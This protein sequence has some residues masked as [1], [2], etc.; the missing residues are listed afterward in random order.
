MTD[1]SGWY[2]GDPYVF[3]YT[4]STSPRSIDYQMA[5][6]MSATGFDGAAIEILGAGADSGP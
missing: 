6:G 5:N 3:F 1:G 4:N 2:T